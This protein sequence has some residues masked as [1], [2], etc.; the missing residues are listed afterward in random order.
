MEIQSRKKKRRWKL[1]KRK[2]W[3]LSWN[4]NPRHMPEED[5]WELAGL[6]KFW[7]DQ[8]GTCNAL[9]AGVNWSGFCGAFFVIILGENDAFLNCFCKQHTTKQAGDGFFCCRNERVFIFSCCLLKEA[10]LGTTAKAN[11]RK[12]GSCRKR[13]GMGEGAL[14]GGRVWFGLVTCRW[15]GN[16]VIQPLRVWEKESSRPQGPQISFN[17]VSSRLE[18]RWGA[19]LKEVA[20][21]CLPVSIAASPQGRARQAHPSHF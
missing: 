7:A 19:A 5:A 14:L 6:R 17:L 2:Q 16:R 21:S 1:G 3:T 4:D 18:C 13:R 10:G 12:V 8:I 11:G 9:S 20:S 15:G